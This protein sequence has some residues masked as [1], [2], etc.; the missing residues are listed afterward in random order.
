VSKIQIF[1]LHFAVMS[2]FSDE[3]SYMQDLNESNPEMMAINGGCTPLTAGVI[4]GIGI[5]YA[6]AMQ[7][8]K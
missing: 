1:D 5:T 4:V 6:R 8:L 3:E 2:L 7:V